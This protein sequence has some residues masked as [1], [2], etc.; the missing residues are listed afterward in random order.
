[1]PT[2]QRVHATDRRNADDAFRDRGAIERANG[3][4]R[5]HLVDPPP[6]VGR[7]GADDRPAESHES[8]RLQIDARWMRSQNFITPES[9]RT[10]IA[11]DFRRIKRHLL[12][13]S[14]K[15]RVMV[16]SALPGEGKTF[17]AINLAV[18]LA[19]ELDRSV[20][21]VDAD[22]VR[23]SVLQGLGISDGMRGLMDALVEGGGRLTEDLVRRTNIG[24]LSIVP[25]GTHRPNATE[26]LAS[27]MMRALVQD[28]SDRHHDQI[29]IFDSPPL[30]VASESAALA[31]HMSQILMVVAA[32]QTT[33][34]ALKEALK[35][36]DGCNCPIGLVL[37]KSEPTSVG[38]GYYG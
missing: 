4:S 31:G 28:L 19:M 3:A 17:C 6:A 33:E 2:T 8:Q 1:V 16:T 24:R 18:S 37:N 15:P 25:A 10:M 14:P 22:T 21:L 29:V 11:E 32:K 5:A 27:D 9:G 38:Y 34:L 20:V 13:G 26:L 7:G 30:L 12:A 36:I 35:R 23:P